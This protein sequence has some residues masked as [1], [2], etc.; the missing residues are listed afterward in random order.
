MPRQGFPA[1]PGAQAWLDAGNAAAVLEQQ[2]WTAASQRDVVL[3]VIDF[4]GPARCMFA[5]NF[6]VDSLCASFATIFSGFQE[7]VR[8]LSVAEQHGLCR[9]NAI[10]IYAME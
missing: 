5:S 2:A 3:S 6:P 9:D 1:A 8:D 7:I 4:F 10:R